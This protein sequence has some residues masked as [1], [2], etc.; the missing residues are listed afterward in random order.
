MMFWDI[1]GIFIFYVILLL[2]VRQWSSERL[3]RP[4]Q[5]LAHAAERAMTHGDPFVLEESG[6]EEV[7]QLTNSISMFVHSL[8]EAKEEAM[9]ADRAKSEFLA[10]MSHEMRTPLHGILSFSRFGVDESLTADREQLA[11][12]FDKIAQSSHRLLP[13]IDNLLDLF[14][15]E[16]GKAEIEFEETNF[17][18]LAAS[19]VDEVRHWASERGVTI[20]LCQPPFDTTVSV[21]PAMIMQVVRNLLSNAIK[22]SPENSEVHVGFEQGEA[23]LILRVRDRGVGILGNELE[24]VF[25]KFMQSSRTKSGAGGTGLGLAICREIL[26]PHDARIWAENHPEGGAV[27]SVEIPYAP[28]EPEKG[29]EEDTLKE[30][31]PQSEPAL[32]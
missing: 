17:Y 11:N 6:P 4:I 23:R 28:P 20:T 29:D 15:L 21:V 22:F 12:Y 3:V 18:S 2:L 13:L 31:E 26:D 27:F 32:A 1:T 24:A 8:E 16:S 25:D 14:K 19:V 10:N 9:A 5:S 30:V 7:R